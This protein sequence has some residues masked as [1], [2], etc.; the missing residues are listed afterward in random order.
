MSQF[1]ILHI[2]FKKP[3]PEDMAGWN[4]WF[5][6]VA[7]RKVDQGGFRGGREIT[8]AGVADLPFGEESITGFTI[9]EAD[10]LEE[11]E[12]IASA[13][14]VVGATQVYEIMRH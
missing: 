6:S 4:A 8:A 12:Q 7:D 5:Q 10:S 9:I 14:P 1:L 3:S 11:A 13:C 2:G